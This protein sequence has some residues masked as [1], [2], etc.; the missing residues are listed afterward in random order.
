MKEFCDLCGF[1]FGINIPRFWEYDKHYH[2]D[3]GV[4]C[5]SCFKFLYHNALHKQLEQQPQKIQKTAKK[6][7]KIE[8]EVVLDS[9]YDKR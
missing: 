8:P 1:E 5:L 4:Y 6:T 9:G 7:T 2:K 3:G